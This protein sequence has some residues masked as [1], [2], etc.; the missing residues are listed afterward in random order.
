MKDGNHVSDGQFVYIEVENDKKNSYLVYCPSIS[1]TNILT[2]K[3][4]KN[5]KQIHF[6]QEL[7]FSRKK[8]YESSIAL[9]G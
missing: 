2:H 6:I 1:S 9:N 7:G 5:G 3:I 4:P 8:K